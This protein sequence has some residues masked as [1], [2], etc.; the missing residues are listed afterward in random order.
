MS[1]LDLGTWVSAAVAFCVAALV[2][3]RNVMG[4]FLRALRV[5][6]VA[7]VASPAVWLAMAVAGGSAFVGG[8]W[9]GH[10]AGNQG[11]AELREQIESLREGMG[12]SLVEKRRLA[13]ELDETKELL[14][15][16]RTTAQTAAS[17]PR[18]AVSRRPVP[19]RSAPQ[20]AATAPPEPAV[21]FWPFDR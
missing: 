17:A 21:R 13:R 9:L 3:A 4:R 5:S 1:K 11:K 18:T 7:F 19:R 6:F 10:A 16:A 15:D 14:A 20:K 2:G 12:Q 8:W